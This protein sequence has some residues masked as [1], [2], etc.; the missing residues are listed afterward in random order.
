[1]KLSAK[2]GRVYIDFLR[3]SAPSKPLVSPS[4]M[5]FKAGRERNSLE[6]DMM[7]SV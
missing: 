6:I 1:V 4:V 3:N 2:E 5:A 7:E